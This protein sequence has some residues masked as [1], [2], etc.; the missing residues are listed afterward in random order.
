MPR[1]GPPQNLRPAGA[2]DVKKRYNRKREKELLER[3]ED[4][5]G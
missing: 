4:T 5:A 3:Y 2:H 1:L